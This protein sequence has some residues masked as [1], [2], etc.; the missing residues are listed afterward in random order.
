MTATREHVDLPIA[1][2]TCASCA[3]RVERRLNDLDGVRA[4]VNYATEKAAVEFDPAGSTRGGS[5]PPS[6]RPATAPSCP[7]ERRPCRRRRPGADATAA[8]RRRLVVAAVLSVPVLLMSMVPALQFDSF[9]WLSL[10][11]VS[12]GGAVGG[13]G[14]S[15]GPPGRTCGTAPRRWTR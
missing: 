3:T 12:A 11:L 13:L 14:R 8:L 7:R 15:T 1:G 2:M 9:Q 5:S 4:T 10:A 6:R